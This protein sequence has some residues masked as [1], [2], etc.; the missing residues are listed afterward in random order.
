MNKE[1]LFSEQDKLNEVSKI[2]GMMREVKSEKDLSSLLKELSFMNTM[3]LK[4][5]KETRTLAD[6]VIYSTKSSICQWLC[7]NYNNRCRSFQ[8]NILYVYSNN[9]QYSY[10]VSLHINV[11]GSCITYNGY[12][13]VVKSAKYDEWDEIENG[14][15]LTD[16]Q[17]R[18]IVAKKRNIKEPVIRTKQPDFLEKLEALKSKKRE[19]ELEK[20]KIERINFFF[21]MLGN[22]KQ[23]K[24]SKCYKEHDFEKCYIIYADRLGL[25]ESMYSYLID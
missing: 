10:H 25:N 5:Y 15:K 8:N 19:I 22:L 18:S 14:W 11:E 20:Q 9:R 6:Y 12:S 23:A 4:G 21:S 17:Y 16:S 24:K 3:V 7:E 13:T 1:V 2:I